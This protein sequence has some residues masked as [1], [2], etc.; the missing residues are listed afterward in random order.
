MADFKKEGREVVLLGA[1]PTS[2]KSTFLQYLRRL[3]GVETP[4][5]MRVAIATLDTDELI[6]RYI[7]AWFEHRLWARNRDKDERE[8]HNQM[9]GVAIGALAATAIRDRSS[10]MAVMTNLYGEWWNIG[11]THANDLKSWLSEP[12]TK[13]ESSG[14]PTAYFRV[15]NPKVVVERSALR[16]SKGQIPLALAE[17]WSRTSH[18]PSNVTLYEFHS[19]LSYL[20]RATEVMVIMQEYFGIHLHPSQVCFLSGVLLRDDVMNVGYMNKILPPVHCSFMVPY[21]YSPL[22]QAHPCLKLQGVKNISLSSMRDDPFFYE[23]DLCCYKWGVSFR[24]LFAFLV[25]KTSLG[26]AQRALPAMLLDPVFLDRRNS[27][28]VTSFDESRGTELLLK[29][30]DSLLQLFADLGSHDSVSGFDIRTEIREV[31]EQKDVSEAAEECYYW[32]TGTHNLTD[33]RVSF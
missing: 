17:K 30:D 31:A 7:P 10:K 12:K 1:G 9:L 25:L 13:L 4:A 16:S 27:E 22:R 2:G 24:H 3:A 6:G 20:G 29:T 23:Y 33:Y 15:A 18:F 21:D 28:P 14:W 5:K 8:V 26:E 11:L 32:W 19:S